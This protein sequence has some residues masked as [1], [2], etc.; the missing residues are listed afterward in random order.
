MNRLI[1]LLLSACVML[2]ALGCEPSS[3]ACQGAECSNNQPELV[4]IGIDHFMEP[5]RVPFGTWCHRINSGSGFTQTHDCIEGLDTYEWGTRY[6]V[7]AERRQ[8]DNTELDDARCNQVYS[9]LEVVSAQAVSADT[10]F[11]IPAMDASFLENLQTPDAVTLAQ[12]PIAENRDKTPL[13]LK[14]SQTALIDKL[15]GRTFDL[16]VQHASEGR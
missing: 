10:V 2:L 8:V 3:E 15:D 4:E 6:Q 1:T 13:S 12:E 7:R 16:K 9:I 5:C 11:V 14:T